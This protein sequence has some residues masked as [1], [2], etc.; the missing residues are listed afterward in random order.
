MAYKYS[1]DAGKPATLVKREF[2]RISRKAT[3]RKITIKKSNKKHKILRHRAPD[4]VVCRMQNFFS[5]FFF[6]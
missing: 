3:F 1:H 5:D 2:I 4:K 6:Y